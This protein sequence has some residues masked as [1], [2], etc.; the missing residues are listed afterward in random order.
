MNRRAFVGAAAATSVAGCLG[1]LSG[2]QVDPES[3]LDVVGSKIVEAHNGFYRQRPAF[4][5]ESGQVDFDETRVLDPLDDAEQALQ[6]ADEA[7][8]AD[9]TRTKVEELRTLLGA[10]RNV[11]TSIPDF[12]AVLNEYLPV[13]GQFRD[14]DYEAVRSTVEETKA[15]LEGVPEAFVTGRDRIDGV[16]GETLT[17]GEPFPDSDE[18]LLIDSWRSSADVLHDYAT[19]VGKGL[20]AYEELVGALAELRAAGEA[21]ANGDDA[22]GNLDAASSSLA[23][24]KG[25]ADE[26]ANNVVPDMYAAQFD[27]VVCFAGTGLDVEDRYVA[28][29]TFEL[30]DGNYAE[31]ERL[32]NTALSKLENASCRQ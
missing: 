9:A 21:I 31:A 10:I 12:E 29:A 22:A 18:G 15:D 3:E 6:R 27:P 32:V 16:S 25:N 14:G 2:E 7:A 23:R 4:A 1:V 26:A 11:A 20:A 5:P 24:A 19:S 17:N 8:T 30:D 28:R 13:S